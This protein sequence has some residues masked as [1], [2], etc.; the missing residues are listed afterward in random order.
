MKRASIE[1]ALCWSSRL[2]T[3]LFTWFISSAFRKIGPGARVCPPLRCS[4]LLQ[5]TLGEGTVIHRD[6]WLQT[7]G[8]A[9]VLD[10]GRFAG[11]GMG[12]SISAANRIT[13]GDYVIFGRN[14]FISDHAHAFQDVGLPIS[15]QGIDNVGPVAIGSETW[16]GQNTVVLPGVSIGRHCVIGANS[17]V[18]SSL[19]DFSVAVGAPARVVKRYNSDT[20]SWQRT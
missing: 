10:I 12:A 15:T 1:N 13:I 9:A 7:I 5:I 6:C 20:R 8:D 14:V 19:P 16:L 3:R 18:N 4:G 2:K 11:I 17:V